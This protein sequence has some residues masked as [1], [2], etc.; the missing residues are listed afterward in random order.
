LPLVPVV[1]R[2]RVYAVLAS[3]DSSLDQH[4]EA[5]EWSR[6]AMSSALAC[7]MNRAH[8]YA[9][10]AHAE[11]VLGSDPDSAQRAADAACVAFERGR[12]R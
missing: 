12:A 11:A 2:A 7:G 9:Q 8:G 6:L 4:G 10:L 1:G 3:A 5:R